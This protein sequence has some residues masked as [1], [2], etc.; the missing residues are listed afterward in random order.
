MII[1][2]CVRKAF[3]VFATAF[4]LYLLNWQL[5]LDLM[6][7]ERLHRDRQKAMERCAT[8]DEEGSS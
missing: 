6:L 5:R 4:L 1:G 8:A 3:Q 2:H 7:L